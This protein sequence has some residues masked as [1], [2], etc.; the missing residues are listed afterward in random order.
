MRGIDIS[1]WQ[2]G[3]YTP[4]LDIDFCIVK[5]T[6][7]IGY[8]DP[9]F[10]EFAHDCIT[11]QILFGF[12]HFAREN[13]PEAEAEYFYNVTSYLIGYGIPA[14]D[15][16]TNNADDR[17]W[18]ERFCARFQEL[19]GIWPIMYTYVSK[20]PYLRSFAYTEEC[21]LWIAG[22]PWANPEWTTQYCPYD[23]SPWKRPIIWQFT[24]SLQ[25]DGW[26]GRLDGNIAYIDTD[27]W[28]CLAKGDD[29][30]AITDDDARKIA[31]YVWEYQYQGKDGKDE[32]LKD[33]GYSDTTDSNRY[34]VLN[35]IA[36]I[37]SKIK[38]R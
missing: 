34:N 29:Y 24:S 21:P 9:S 38:A 27:E 6:E 5:A 11:H 19:S 25:L 1:N 18:C 13:S 17:D 2:S 20:L 37:V 12:Y 33:I 14:L 7:G 15:Y 35:A 4:G 30:M 3:L 10:Q 8:E 31:R 28:E 23:C 22:Y 32:I 16:E 36:D 26:Y